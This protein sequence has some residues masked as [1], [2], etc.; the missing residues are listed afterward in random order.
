MIHLLLKDVDLII[1]LISHS[2]LLNDV[3][4]IYLESYR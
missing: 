3:D 1:M 4:L 2:L